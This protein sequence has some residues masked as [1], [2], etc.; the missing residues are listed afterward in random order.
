M[1][2]RK[3]N[4]Y[5]TLGFLIVVMLMASLLAAC[6]PMPVPIPIPLS[7][8]GTPIVIVVVKPQA[9]PAA[10]STPQ[11]EAETAVVEPSAASAEE[12]A[13]DQAEAPPASSI[14][15]AAMEDAPVAIPHKYEGREDCGDC[16]EVGDGKHAAPASHEG[17]SDD[18]CLYCHAP[19]EGDA[20]APPLPDDASPEFCLGC[21]GPYEE[22]LE[23]TVGILTDEDGGK[24]NPHMYVPHD[25]TTITSCKFCH[26][27]HSLPVIPAEIPQA[28]TGY[29][30]AACHH[31]QNFESCTECH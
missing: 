16:H 28:D 8:S 29:C 10:I 2:D 25:S 13:A 4:V 5:A 9:A 22:L 26:E 20:I 27:V 15:E 7:T 11:P 21:H 19:E 17:Y 6:M 30:F 14:V 3:R 24:A 31:E 12:S 18:L 1:C 23:R